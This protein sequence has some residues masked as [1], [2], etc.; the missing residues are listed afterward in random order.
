MEHTLGIKERTSELQFL[1]KKERYSPESPALGFLMSEDIC[2][3]L[4]HEFPPAEAPAL[5][6]AY[7]RENIVGGVRYIRGVSPKE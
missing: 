6:P 1:S 3:S 7:H 2:H 5:V 4:I